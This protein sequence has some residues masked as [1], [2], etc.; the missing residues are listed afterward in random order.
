MKAAGLNGV[1]Y[2]AVNTSIRTRPNLFLD[3][4]DTWLREKRWKQQRLVL[5]LEGTKRPADVSFYKP[6]FLLDTVLQVLK[7]ILCNMLEKYIED[8]TGLSD[9]PLGFRKARLKVNVIETGTGMRIYRET[10]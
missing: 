1:R 5:L 9:K 6:I 3:V 7:R 10:N 4:Y 2:V 8:A